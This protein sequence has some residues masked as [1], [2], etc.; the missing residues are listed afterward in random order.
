MTL[1]KNEKVCKKAPK[2]LNSLGLVSESE[3]GSVDS[4]SDSSEFSDSRDL[5]SSTKSSKKS[6]KKKKVFS[7][8]SSS[9]SSSSEESDVYSKHRTRKKKK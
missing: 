4:S 7:S 6:K 9:S 8:S 3:H 2:I 1:E 5:Y